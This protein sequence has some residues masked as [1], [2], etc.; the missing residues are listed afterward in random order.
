MNSCRCLLMVLLLASPLSWGAEDIVVVVNPQNSVQSLSRG[1]IID[2]YMGRLRQFPGGEPAAAVDYLS[3]A[4]IRTAFYHQ[5]MRRSLAQV[6]AYW[7]RLLFNG[8][9]RPPLKVAGAGDVITA[10]ASDRSAIGYIYSNEVT[11]TVKV[12]ARITAD[13]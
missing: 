12:V 6:N 3:E 10:V 7:A 5:L 4:P 9:A 13:P 8:S 1:E 2:L 11:G